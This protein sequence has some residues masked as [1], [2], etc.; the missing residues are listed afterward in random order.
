[1]GGEAG[2]HSSLAAYLL[3]TWRVKRLIHD[4]RCAAVGRLAGSAQFTPCDAGIG[5]RED[6]CLR[7]GGYEGSVSQAYLLTDLQGEAAAVRFAG[8]R[9]FYRLDLAEGRGYAVHECAPDRYVGRYW[10]VGADCWRLAWRIT[11][12]RKDLLVATR[13][14]RGSLDGI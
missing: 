1:M 2:L 14:T 12:P 5:W 11:G 13:Y 6:G 10:R 4:R 8:G 7:F 3:G 9:F